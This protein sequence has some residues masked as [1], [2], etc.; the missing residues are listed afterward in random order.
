MRGCPWRASSIRRHRE[1]RGT[2]RMTPC[3]VRRRWRRGLGLLGGFGLGQDL[4]P[5]D[6]LHV[7][8]LVGVFLNA[9]HELLLVVGLEHP[10]A[11]T[12]DSFLHVSPQFNPHELT[13]YA[14]SS[15][16]P[17][18]RPDGC[19]PRGLGLGNLWRL[20]TALPLDID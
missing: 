1:G 14:L 13:G 9:L 8:N 19:H 15:R 20:C 7:V 6:A 17:R 16:G 5:G 11:F 12:L 3:V 2:S 10:A 18:V 4:I